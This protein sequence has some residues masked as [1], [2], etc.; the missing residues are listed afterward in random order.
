MQLTLADH[1]PA[2][3][4]R[5]HQ[6]LT[7]RPEAD[8]IRLGVIAQ[9]ETGPRQLT[10]RQVE[11]TFHLVVTALSKHELDGAPSAELQAACGDLLEA[12]IPGQHE[13]ACRSLAADRTDVE[14]WSRPPRHGSTACHDP[15]ARWGHRNTNLPGPRARCSSA[16]TCP[17][18]SW[19][20]TSTARP[21]PSWPAG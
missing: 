5:M 2:Q 10:Y 16:T 18:P 3:L 8:Q 7:G 13:P 11:H 6:A 9:W 12:G 15:E 17:P 19:S 4:T 14:S 21:C 20:P 1:R